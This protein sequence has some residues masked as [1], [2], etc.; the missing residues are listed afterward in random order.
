MTGSSLDTLPLNLTR[1]LG[2]R[3]FVS[4]VCAN[5]CQNLD[6]Q[7]SEEFF[8]KRPCRIP[9]TTKSSTQPSEPASHLASNPPPRQ[10]VTAQCYNCHTTAT[11]LWRSVMRGFYFYCYLSTINFWYTS[12]LA[13]VSIS[14]LVFGISLSFAFHF[15]EHSVSYSYSDSGHTSKHRIEFFGLRSVLA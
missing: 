15:F 6:L 5:I 12:S 2:I 3:N 9:W 1:V 10:S 4:V 14:S 8:W 13:V 11:T 7:S